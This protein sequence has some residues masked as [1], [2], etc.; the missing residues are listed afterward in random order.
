MQKRKYGASPCHQ[1]LV[2]SAR[3]QAKHTKLDDLGGGSTSYQAAQVAP[4]T[5]AEDDQSAQTLSTQVLHWL[6]KENWN[7]DTV[8]NQTIRPYEASSI[9]YNRTELNANKAKP[10]AQ[11]AGYYVAA[12]A[13]HIQHADAA[14]DN[15]ISSTLH[16]YGHFNS[17][18][19]KAGDHALYLPNSS[20]QGAQSQQTTLDRHT[21]AT[22]SATTRLYEALG[23]HQ[24]PRR[25]QLE[26]SGEVAAM[27][28]KKEPLCSSEAYIARQD[29]HGLGGKNTSHEI[30]PSGREFSNQR[31]T[32]ECVG[33][34]FHLAAQGR[35]AAV[36][37]Y[38]TQDVF[39]SMREMVANPDPSLAV[40]P[41]MAN[42]I[43]EEP[44]ETRQ[45]VDGEN[46]NSFFSSATINPI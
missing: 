19:P 10:E 37:P 38:D 33:I 44:N 7:D 20:E 24:Q 13:S 2:G 36:P 41:S 39:I 11:V 4:L 17:N 16:Q 43:A 45:Q 22:H 23:L 31:N 34:P 14:A 32:G 15:P 1:L 35:H 26:Y 12:P 21:L 6:D 42:I 46:G 18:G 9:D 28:I 29:S 27:E 40:V 3:R 30:L 8:W 25:F 5:T